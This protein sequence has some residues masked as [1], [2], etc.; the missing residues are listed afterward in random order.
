MEFRVSMGDHMC[1]CLSGIDFFDFQQHSRGK[2][3]V[4]R[5][6]PTAMRHMWPTVVILNLMALEYPML[7]LKILMDSN[8]NFSKY[9]DRLKG[10]GQV[11]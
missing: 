5:P 2:G 1:F 8:L 3:M 6:K 9:R 4:S 7:K 10:I 11:V